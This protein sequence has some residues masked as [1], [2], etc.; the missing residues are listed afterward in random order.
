MEEPRKKNRW[1]LEESWPHLGR[2]QL[3][4]S[5]EIPALQPSAGREKPDVGDG[6]AMNREKRDGGRTASCRKS[7]RG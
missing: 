5:K 1:I 3:R 2:I 6:E 4:P 7:R